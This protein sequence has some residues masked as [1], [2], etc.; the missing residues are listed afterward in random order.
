MSEVCCYADERFYL[1]AQILMSFTIYR[2]GF[3]DLKT[4]N[5]G[6]CAPVGFTAAGVHAGLSK[7]PEKNDLGLIFC[8]EKCSAAAV[9]TKNKVKGSPLIVTGKHISDG[10]IQAVVC[11][12]A[13]ANTCCSDGEEKAEKM[14]MTAAENLGISAEDIAVASTGVIG[15]S[16][17]LEPVVNAFPKLVSALSENGSESCARAIMTTDTTVKETA[18]EFDIGGKICRI[19]GIAKGSGMIHPNM[20]TVLCF[21][22]TDCDI[23]PEML[24]AAL[25]ENARVTFNRVSVDGDTSTND[26]ALI[27]ADGLAGN[28]R[29]TEN[30]ADFEIFSNALFEVMRYLT[31]KIAAD[32]DGET[33]MIE[34]VCSGADSEETA[35][36]IA[37]SVISSNLVKAMVGGG[38]PNWGRISC[39]AGYS[40]ADFDPAK[41]N[42]DFASAKEGRI[43]VCR[44]GFGVDFSEDKARKILLDK[45]VYIYI[46]INCGNFEAAAW[47]CTLTEN[48]V[49]INGDY[50]GIKAREIAGR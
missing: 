2:G 38:D 21:I 37:K 29:I 1:K 6:V 5:G 45:E 35:E 15:R 50:R 31:R 19:G 33:R 42:I 34:C 7:R 11:N 14:C 26:M 49:R 16:L 48:Y 17:D 27:M 25:A 23:S 44:N 32:G 24:K 47:G 36:K 9:Y 10:I 46:D 20:A 8:R 12:S 3:M 40:G 41:M 39:A 28:R 13:N 43:S 30:N 18:A 22:T 4:I